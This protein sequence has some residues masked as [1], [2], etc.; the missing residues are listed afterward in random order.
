MEQSSTVDI[1]PGNQTKIPIGPKGDIQPFIGGYKITGKIDQAKVNETR[2][3]WY[4]TNVSVTTGDSDFDAGSKTD[5]RVNFNLDSEKIDYASFEIADRSDS[6]AGEYMI[7]GKIGSYSTIFNGTKDTHKISGEAGGYGRSADLSQTGVWNVTLNSTEPGTYTV[8]V[9]VMPQVVTDEG[10]TQDTVTVAAH[11]PVTNATATLNRSFVGLV[12]DAGSLS[13]TI[14]AFQDATG[15]EIT[16]TNATVRTITIAGQP[17]ANPQAPITGN[18]ITVTG[19]DPT[20]L[21]AEQL[22]TGQAPVRATI[23]TATGNE[24]TV[25]LGT[26]ALV[27]EVT[28]PESTDGT[29]TP[30]TAPMPYTEIRYAGAK[31]GPDGEPIEVQWNATAGTYEPIDTTTQ[32]HKHLPNSWYV[33]GADRVGYIYAKTANGPQTQNLTAGWHRLGPTVDLTTQASWAINESLPTATATGSVYHEGAA[34]TNMTQRTVGPYDAYWVNVT[35]TTACT[36]PEVAYEPTAR[37]TP[38]EA[39]S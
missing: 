1:N 28:S 24:T 4:P 29:W 2:M 13:I 27:H 30:V 23:A 36:V 22:S 20:T 7:S 33:A 8:G 17:V 32:A 14:S 21:T 6:T 19:V 16:N 3:I 25:E 38:A 31:T 34:V 5:L 26:I 12:K 39:G 35:N 11:G 15:I 18:S 37:A 9:D 10:M